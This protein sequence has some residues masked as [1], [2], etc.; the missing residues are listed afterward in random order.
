MSDRAVLVVH[1]PN[2]NLLGTREPATYGTATV[3][4]HVATVRS[5]L[6]PAG[7]RVDSFVSN[8][9]PEMVGAVQGARGTYDAIVVNAGALT[10]YSWA[11]HDALRTYEGTKIEVHISN[12]AAR[13]PFRHVSVLAPVV[14]GSIAGL[15]GLG[16]ELA[17]RAVL[18]HNA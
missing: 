3:D 5:V 11:L 10:H 17:A 9:E 8:S 4:D 7:W 12:P 18:A 13:E 2:L 14:H 6:G 16:Y 15:G 1:G